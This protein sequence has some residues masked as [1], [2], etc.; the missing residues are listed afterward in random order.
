MMVEPVKQSMTEKLR[1]R[2]ASITL[3][4]M[5]VIVALVLITSPLWQPVGFF[6]ALIVGAISAYAAPRLLRILDDR[7]QT[8]GRK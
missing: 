3:R 4:E 8:G 7:F 1:E 2:L 6:G 5:V